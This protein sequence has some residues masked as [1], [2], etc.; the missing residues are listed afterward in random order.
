MKH[1]PN[2]VSRALW[3]GVLFIPLCLFPAGCGGRLREK[4]AEELL[5]A[6][7]ET[8]LSQAREELL[9]LEAAQEYLSRN[10]EIEEGIQ[11]LNGTGDPAG[12]SLPGL[13]PELAELDL[14][15]TQNP[16]TFT[17]E[18]YPQRRLKSLH[19]EC[20]YA[21][22]F[23]EKEVNDLSFQ[24]SSAPG[25]AGDL[26]NTP[27]SPSFV[28]TAVTSTATFRGVSAEPARLTGYREWHTSPLTHYLNFDLT[29]VLPS[30]ERAPFRSL[31][32][33][34]GFPTQEA[35]GAK[36]GSFTREVVLQDG[37]NDTR[38]WELSLSGNTLAVSYSRHHSS[39]FTARGSGTINTQ[40]TRCR[41]DDV[42]SFTLIRT[43][44]Q[45][46]TTEVQPVS[47][48]VMTSQNANVMEENGTLYLSDGTTRNSS[49]TRTIVNPTQCG[50]NELP[51]VEQVRRT[52]YR[53]VEVE[54]TV[55]K[56][57][58]GVAI[59]GT[60][61]LP[62]GGTQNYTIVR[63]ASGITTVRA[64]STRA[65]GARAELD[66]TVSPS[67][68][69]VGTLTLTRADG[70]VDLIEVNRDLKGYKLHRAG[71]PRSEFRRINRGEL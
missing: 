12:G 59:T 40:G 50:D 36:Y 9:A 27:P 61:T 53:G 18:Q 45:E 2:I 62:N 48:V 69:A 25:G 14:V 13:A 39:G 46:N 60:R 51:W 41:R 43:F 56:T 70:T 44:P 17:T 16:C 58:G 28:S 63:T 38:T 7:D 57:E 1:S 6:L 65:N 29:L 55:T 67:G 33:Y 11:D 19:R 47:E 20:N 8:T 23:V 35:G 26:N 24:W 37:S 3:A 34:G 49:T 66:L 4:I 30:L 64:T 42:G 52:S 71:R 21:Q 5:T 15:A 68:H 32:W 54:F 31:H 10:G 22:G